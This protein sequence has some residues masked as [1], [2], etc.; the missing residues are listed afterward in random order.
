MIDRRLACLPILATLP[1]APARGAEDLG[2]FLSL[3]PPQWQIG[4]YEVRLGGSLAGALFAASQS[5]GPMRPDGYDNTRSSGEARASVRV[6]RI[7]DNGMVLGARS[8]FLVY[9]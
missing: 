8:D 3:E 2:D 6:Q 7:L 1:C 5:A 9:R 4:D